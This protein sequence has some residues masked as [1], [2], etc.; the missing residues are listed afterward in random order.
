MPYK[1][2]GRTYLLASSI[3]GRVFVPELGATFADINQ[4]AESLD[5]S[6]QRIAKVLTGQNKTAGGYHF[7]PGRKMPAAEDPRDKL[8]AKIKQQIKEANDL[9]KRVRAQKRQG[10]CDAINDLEDFGRDVI[11]ST[12]D[13]LI[14]ETS[15]VLD[16]MDESELNSLTDKLDK[17]LGKAREDAEK[18]EQRLQEYA[19]MFGIS[20]AEMEKYEHLI[21]EINQT[22]DRAKA[23]GVGSD[24]L[25]VIKDLMQHGIKPEALKSFLDK[26]NSFFNNPTRG[27]NIYDIL[28]KWAA[29]ASGG[30]SWEDFEAETFDTP[31]GAW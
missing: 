16:D 19:D 4:A 29:E 8:R 12:G 20:S 26:C 21:P 22:I 10:F 15:D 17:M 30:A 25:E 2:R 28:G 1:Y 3:P 5:I 6:V 13:N 7:K 31:W 11:G 18:A 24:V 27:A 14:D 9:I 23:M